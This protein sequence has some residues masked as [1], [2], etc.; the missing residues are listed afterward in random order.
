M[1]YDHPS[2]LPIAVLLSAVL[3]LLLFVKKVSGVSTQP[4]ALTPHQKGQ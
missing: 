4:A 3:E 1:L 2:L